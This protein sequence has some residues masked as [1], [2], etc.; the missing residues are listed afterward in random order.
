MNPGFMSMILKQKN[1][2]KSGST[3]VVRTKKARKSHLKI[4]T[5]LTVLFGGVVHH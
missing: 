5:M 3:V 4:K 1:R 2:G